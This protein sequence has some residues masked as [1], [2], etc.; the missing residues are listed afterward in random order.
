MADLGV[1]RE[2][3]NAKFNRTMWWLEYAYRLIGFIN[4]YGPL[5]DDN[6]FA[7]VLNLNNIVEHYLLTGDPKII[8]G[9]TVISSK[10]T[11]DNK[12]AEETFKEL[13]SVLY[14]LPVYSI[15]EVDQRL[16]RHK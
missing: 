10:C 11:L 7:L 14:Q 6:Y 3:R 13:R 8:S 15:C 2:Y 16:A 4:T 9:L 1:L 12:T 5:Y